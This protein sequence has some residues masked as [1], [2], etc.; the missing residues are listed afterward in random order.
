MIIQ[1]TFLTLYLWWLEISYW[2]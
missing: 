1:I 2:I